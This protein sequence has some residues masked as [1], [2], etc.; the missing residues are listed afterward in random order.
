MESNVEKVDVIILAP[1]MFVWDDGQ[2]CEPISY[3][4]CI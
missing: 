4:V 3:F 2:F 1:V